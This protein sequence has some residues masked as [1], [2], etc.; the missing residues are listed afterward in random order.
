LDVRRQTEKTINIKQQTRTTNIVSRNLHI[1]VIGGKSVV[2]S[3]E[4]F[5][6]LLIQV[7]EK[8]LLPLKCFFFNATIF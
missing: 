1:I 5:I 6:K 8:Y 2:F 4:L 7:I 3:G